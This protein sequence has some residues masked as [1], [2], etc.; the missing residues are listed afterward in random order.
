MNRDLGEYMLLTVK[1]WAMITI[2]MNAISC[3]T[4]RKCD[5][6]DICGESSSRELIELAG[7]FGSAKADNR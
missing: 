4:P 5:S 6:L 7:S 3:H 1:T 2:T